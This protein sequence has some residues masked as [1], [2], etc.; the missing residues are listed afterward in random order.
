MIPAAMASGW[1]RGSILRMRTWRLALAASGRAGGLIYAQFRLSQLV[2]D[3]E[4]G[5]RAITRDRYFRHDKSLCMFRQT[6]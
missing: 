2:A 5:G 3:G 4:R 1:S 6:S